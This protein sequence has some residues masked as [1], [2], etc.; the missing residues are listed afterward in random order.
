MKKN[1]GKPFFSNPNSLDQE[2]TCDTA[3]IKKR[4]RKDYW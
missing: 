1:V 4:K 3:D 2:I